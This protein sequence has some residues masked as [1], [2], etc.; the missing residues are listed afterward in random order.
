MPPFLNLARRQG[1]VSLSLTLM[2][3]KPEVCKRGLLVQPSA[4][5]ETER[6]GGKGCKKMEIGFMMSV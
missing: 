1:L 3:N 5:V 2:L 4:L 6:E